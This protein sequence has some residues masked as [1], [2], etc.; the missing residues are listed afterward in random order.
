MS[1]LSKKIDFAVVINV[2]NA[3]PN[4]DPN[5]DNRPR[6]DYDG[7]GEISDV[8]IKRKL[9]NRLM[10]EGVNIFVQSNDNKLDDCESLCERVEKECK[11]I[12][13]DA[14]K[15]REASCKKWFDVRAFGNV[16]ALK[17][18]G[19]KDDDDD[20]SRKS[21][22]VGIRGPVSICSAYSIGKIDS[23]IIETQ[24]TKSVNGENVKGKTGDDKSSDTMGMK[25]RVTNAKYVFFGSINPQLATKTGFSNEDADILK[26]ILPNMFLNDESSARPAGSMSVENVYWWEQEGTVGKYSPAK[27]QKSLSIEDENNISVLPLGELT[28]EI[29]EG[30]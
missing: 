28:P 17:A 4:G 15:L 9:R 1:T 27:I 29:I 2:K 5:N 21:I 22:G 23:K 13:T 7:I 16:F 24:I 8:C 12:M 11:T 18:K 26:K 19:K 25:Y 6:V 20:D 14:K 30:Y 10:N 3:N